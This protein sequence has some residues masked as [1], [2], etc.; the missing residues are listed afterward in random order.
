LGNV[1]YHVYILYR[2]ENYLYDYKLL[3]YPLNNLSGLFIFS[4]DIDK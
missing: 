1:E 2:L 4:F 3:V